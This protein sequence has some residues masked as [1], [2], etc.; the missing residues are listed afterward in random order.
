MMMRS[1]FLFSFS[2]CNNKFRKLLKLD[3]TKKLSK[4]LESLMEKSSISNGVLAESD[5]QL[6]SLWALR[7]GVAEAAGKTGK[8]YK[9]DLSLPVSEMY[10][11]TEEMRARFKEKGM[12]ADGD[13]SVKQVI[14]YGH[15]GD[16]NIHL[17]VVAENYDKRIED[18][19]EPWVYERVG[20]F[21]TSHFG[22]S[23]PVLKLKILCY[24]RS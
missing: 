24:S 15:L 9:Y 14:G 23:I 21:L 6:Q 22:R 2:P 10:A 16:G 4:L 20:K 5:S 8:V 3:T 12:D 11:L 19:I 13:G 17:N 7:E 18:V 1:V